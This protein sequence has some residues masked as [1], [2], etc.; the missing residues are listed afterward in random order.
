MFRE[1]ELVV[2]KQSQLYLARFSKKARVDICLHC[3]WHAADIEVK[4]E[5][6]LVLLPER[7]RQVK[8]IPIEELGKPQ[9]AQ[10]FDKFL[11]GHGMHIEVVDLANRPRD[12]LRILLLR[13][14]PA[15]GD[16]QKRA[17]GNNGNVWAQFAELLK[18]RSGARA[19]LNLVEEYKGAPVGGIGSRI[20]RNRREKTG[21]VKRSGKHALHYLVVEKR[22]VRDGIKVLAAKL[23]N[24][25]GLPH[26]ARARHAGYHTR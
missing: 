9:L 18:G 23:Q 16:A 19:L 21:G 7:T 8:R 3:L 20:R 24:K 26:L 11:E 17:R 10:R 2:A 14:E 1:I 12:W 13:G 6:I 5:Q 22:H 4:L 25:P 15:Y